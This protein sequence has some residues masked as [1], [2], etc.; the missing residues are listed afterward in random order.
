MF[1]ITSTHRKTQFRPI[2]SH[3][4]QKLAGEFASACSRL[5]TMSRRTIPRVAAWLFRI[6][7]FAE[8]SDLLCYQSNETMT[9]AL[10]AQF[11]LGTNQESTVLVLHVQGSALLTAASC[12][13]SA[14]SDS[15]GPSRTNERNNKGVAWDFAARD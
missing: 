12:G 3:K 4:I 2:L 6:H 1:S 13:D 10:P 8:L 15:R 5:F 11:L 7:F 14:I 9:C